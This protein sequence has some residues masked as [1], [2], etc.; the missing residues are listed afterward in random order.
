VANNLELKAVITADDKASQ[1]LS[2]FGKSLER[3]ETGSFALLGGLTALA[4]AAVLTV[5]AFGESEDTAAQLDAVLKSTAGAAGVTKQA[6]LDLAAGLQATTT[7]S[8]EA[9]LSAENL[10]LTFTSIGKD[11]FPEA[12][13]TVL[14]MS[15]ALGQDTK[16]SAVQLG[17]ALQDPINGVTALRRVGVNFSE[18]QQ[19]VI[20][21]LVETGRSAEAQKLI[22]KELNTEFGGSATA[23]AST[24]NGQLKQVWNNI[25]DVME[26]VGKLIAD[27]IR[28]LTQAF[29]D[30]FNAMGGSQG[31]M[32]RFTATIKEW[33]DKGYI[34][35]AAGAILGGLVPALWAMAAAIGANVIALAPFMIAGAALVFLFEKAPAVFWAVVGAISAVAVAIMVGAVPAALTGA[36]AFGTMAIAVVAA[37]W[38]FILIGALVGVVAYA[39]IT[40]WNGVRDTVI[41]V[42]AAIGGALAQAGQYFRGLPPVV[43]AAMAS[44]GQSI[45]TAMGPLGM[46]IRLAMQAYDTISNLSRAIG[47][48]DLNAKLH[49]LKIPG[50]ATGVENFSGGLAVVGE[51]GPE[52]VN[53][54]R[55][56]SVIPNNQIGGAGGTTN[57][58]ITFTGPML[59]NAAEAREFARTI[60]NAL[61]DVAGQKNQTVMEYLT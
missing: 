3:A 7:Y 38:P 17:K 32:D 20:K 26:V 12:T 44:V 51:R 18:A 11:I 6:A 36:A 47:G 14:D 59:G 61:K 13:R 60:G 37:T 22:L 53:L 19:E 40:N 39:I 15:T 2:G 52:L 24:F 46:F 54:P 27:Q 30:W 10:L 58:N 4:G 25:N 55:G 41:A 16:A 45:L 1:V 48:K 57:V 56:S 23:A 28:P 34:K 43:Q 21:N 35:I 42:T 31:I 50:F 5:K 8:D 9:V 29:L 33:N 49:S